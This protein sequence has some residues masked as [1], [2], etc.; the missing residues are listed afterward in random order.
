MSELRSVRLSQI[1]PNPFRDI[2]SYPFDEAKIERL[3]ESINSTG[4]WPSVIVRPKGNRFECA[5]GHHRL[6]AAERAGVTTAY[7]VVQDLSDDAMLKM[8]VDENATE[9]GHD[10]FTILNSVSAVVRAYGAGSIKLDK[11]ESRGSNI[12]KVGLSEYSALTVASYLGWTTTDSKGQVRAAERVLTAI[13]ALDLIEQEVLTID[14]FR[15]KSQNDAALMVKVARARGRAERADIDATIKVRTDALKRA[16]KEGD[17]NKAEEIRASVANLEE[18]AD[19]KA[20]RAMRAAA[21]SA[22]EDLKPKSPKEVAERAAPQSR[23]TETRV[24]KTATQT[25]YD[26]IARW[27]STCLDMD[28]KWVK[29]GDASAK[30][31]REAYEALMRLS[32]RAKNRAKEIE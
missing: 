22:A 3:V 1:D 2:E 11:P 24:V 25:L 5:F 16:E 18:Q 19:Q 10:F 14:E 7:V 28:P 23:E 20:L 30:A 27:E 9:Y 13:G 15:G 6:D 17:T 31:K 4:F 8:M 26:L 29:S 32:E 12:R 21:K